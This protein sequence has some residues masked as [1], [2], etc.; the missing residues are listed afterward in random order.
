[1]LKPEFEA[2]LVP[3]KSNE[4][5]CT[6]IKAGTK[7]V[8]CGGV[9]KIYVSWPSNLGLESSEENVAISI[10]PTSLEDV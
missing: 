1:M 2:V 6:G 5:E 9:S 4:I 7:S 3:L 8:R 10:P